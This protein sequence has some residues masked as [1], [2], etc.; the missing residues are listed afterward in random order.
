MPTDLIRRD[1]LS[2]TQTVDRINRANAL[3]FERASVT[4]DLTI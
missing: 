4:L 2:Y 1:E 3:T